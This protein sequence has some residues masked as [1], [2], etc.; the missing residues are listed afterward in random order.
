[1]DRLSGVGLESND[2]IVSLIKGFFLKFSFC[3]DL[4]RLS[5]VG[6]ESND[7]IVSLIKGTF[8]K[9]LFA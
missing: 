5:G 6:L 1:M 9:Y 2:L 4:E 8:L 7:L 3:L